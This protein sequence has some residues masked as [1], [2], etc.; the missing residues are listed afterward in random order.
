MS[1][2]PFIHTNPR[3]RLA[4]LPGFSGFVVF[5][6]IGEQHYL[7]WRDGV[8][9]TE[10]RCLLQGRWYCRGGGLNWSPTRAQAAKSGWHLF[11]KGTPLEPWS[12]AA[13]KAM[14]A[15]STPQP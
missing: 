2:S 5:E 9:A 1:S 15:Q 7:M 12:D 3:C 11:S 6:C 4:K 14:S 8:A 10:V 13:K